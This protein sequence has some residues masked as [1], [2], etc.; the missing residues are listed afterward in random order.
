M[1]NSYDDIRVLTSLGLTPLQAEVYVALSK[2]G[3]ATIKTLSS[4]SKID[5]ANIYRVMGRLQE[6][7][8]VEKLLT[9]P[10]LFKALPMNEGILMLL[11]H[12]EVEHEE[13]KAKAKELLKTYKQKNDLASVENEC[14][15]AI[16]PDGKLT[17]RKV[18]E[19][20]DSNKTAHEIIIYWKD[21]EPLI[22]EV[23]SMWRTVLLKGVKMRVIVFLQ[24]K[25]RLPKEIESFKKYEQFE[26]R[27]TSTPPKVT[28]SIID[29]KEAFLSVTPTL[30]HGDSG[31]LW[32]NNP[33]IVGIIREYF[34]MVW[35]NSKPLL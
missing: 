23:V 17:K 6:L 34:E 5:R 14:Q 9:T 22:S 3:K 11:E 27:K 24:E 25:E 31:G 16:I 13:V 1:Q 15:F 28:L 8:L 26:I 30:P 33:G 12:K 10:T 29:G 2:M 19:M 35:R 4:V 7:N 32:L 20:I 18:A 21:F